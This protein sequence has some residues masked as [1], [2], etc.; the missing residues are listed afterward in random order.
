[1]VPSSPKW[2]S[3]NV[4]HISALRVNYCHKELL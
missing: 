4:A 1:V 3:H 2:L